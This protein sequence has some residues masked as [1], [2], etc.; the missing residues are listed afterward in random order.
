MRGANGVKAAI[1]RKGRASLTL[2]WAAAHAY[3]WHEKRETYECPDGQDNWGIQEFVILH[4]AW[5]Q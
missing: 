3:R 5:L 1:F 4:A 2:I